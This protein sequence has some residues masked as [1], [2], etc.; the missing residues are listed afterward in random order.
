M[1]NPDPPLTTKES[2]NEGISTQILPLSRLSLSSSNS[3]P[4]NSSTSN[5]SE[6]I[7]SKAII[8]TP[9]GRPVAEVQPFNSDEKDSNKVVTR[10]K[11]SPVR[12]KFDKIRRSLTEPLIQY[13]HD[14][15][16]SPDSEEPEILNTPKSIA[17]PKSSLSPKDLT[18]K[19]L[20]PDDI[21]DAKP[22][23]APPLVTDM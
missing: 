2:P 10:V 18:S 5:E 3:S 20:F 7:T 9:T 21:E 8:E 15:Q 1:S 17:P 16:S 22:K 11:T 12:E 14:L 23:Q 4:P 19:V 6:K 13:F